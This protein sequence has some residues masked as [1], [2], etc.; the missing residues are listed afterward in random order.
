MHKKKATPY[1]QKTFHNCELC[2]QTNLKCVQLST[3]PKYTRTNAHLHNF[4]NLPC[5]AKF[6][7]NSLITTAIYSKQKSQ[8][9]ASH[10]IGVPTFLYS[11]ERSKPNI[12]FAQHKYTD[13]HTATCCRPSGNRKTRFQ[14]QIQIYVAHT[15]IYGMLTS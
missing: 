7:I 15:I 14:V 13:T 4:K 6:T 8:P 10:Q 9:T 12:D 1:D 3:I 2:H 5:Y 11:I